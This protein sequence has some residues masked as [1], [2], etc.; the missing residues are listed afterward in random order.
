MLQDTLVF[1]CKCKNGTQPNMALYQQ[2]VPGLMCRYWFDLC[3]NATGSDLA[4]QYACTSTRDSQCGNLTTKAE[5]T[6]SSKTSTATA[7]SA[8]GS[9]TATTTG[10]GASQS[11]GAAAALALAREYGT[12][13]LAG[14][15]I[16]LFG[17]AL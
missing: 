12:P 9:S 7:T 3:I 13:V 15:M 1:S 6:S 17:F 5:S 8:S 14:G 2:S 11:S 10:S 4:Q 16:A